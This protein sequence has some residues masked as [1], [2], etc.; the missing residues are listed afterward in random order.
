MINITNLTQK[1][2][3]RILLDSITLTV[4]EKTV[5]GIFCQEKSEREALMESLAG[6]SHITEGEISICGHNITT[7]RLGAQLVIGYMPENMSFYKNMTV[8]EYLSFLA[9][10]KQ[11]D[12]EQAQK[13]IKNTLT[14]TGLLTIKDALISKLSPTGKARLGIAQAIVSDPLVLLFNNPTCGLSRNETQEILK[15]IYTLSKSKSVILASDDQQVFSFCDSM[16]VIS[17][18]QLETDTK[19]FIGKGAK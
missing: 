8:I 13:N 9:E 12:F 3:D 4:P 14:A 17:F 11:L 19:R 16:A 2:G 5:F 6:V 1:Y 10:T 7:D 18:G 15:L